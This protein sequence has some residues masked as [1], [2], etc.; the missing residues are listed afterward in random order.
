MKWLL[1]YTVGLFLVSC[2]ITPIEENLLYTKLEKTVWVGDNNY[3]GCDCGFSGVIGFKEGKIYELSDFS[4]KEATGC[5]PYN[6]W[7]RDYKGEIKNLKNEANKISFNIISGNWDWYTEIELINE[8]LRI[9]SS[10]P[11]VSVQEYNKSTIK[12]EGYCK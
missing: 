7:Y 1:F 8:K 11:F 9:T 4:S 10:G 5:Y 12:F 6:F 2:S 3:R